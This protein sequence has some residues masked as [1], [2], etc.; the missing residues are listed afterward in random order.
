MNISLLRKWLLYSHNLN[1]IR[2]L[3][4]WWTNLKAYRFN[5]FSD[6]LC[7]FIHLLW[8]SLEH[9]YAIWA[10]LISYTYEK[11][12]TKVSALFGQT[13][14]TYICTCRYN[15]WLKAVNPGGNSSV[16][17]HGVV[18]FLRV[19]S[20]SEN[21]DLWVSILRNFRIYVCTFENSPD[22]LVWFWEILRFFT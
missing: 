15:F 5:D 16:R 14:H 11:R 13:I 9:A 19:P 3:K 2:H 10:T 21:L 1:C 7:R 17:W 4:L 12:I 18:P 20:S 8:G 22:L 6:F